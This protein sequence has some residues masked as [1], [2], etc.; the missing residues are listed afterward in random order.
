VLPEVQFLMALDRAGWGWA[1]LKFTSLR[2]PWKDGRG[3]LFRTKSDGAHLDSSKVA[4]CREQGWCAIE[5]EDRMIFAPLVSEESPPIIYHVTPPDN[6]P[7][8]RSRG[9][10]IGRSAGVSTT[11]WPGAGEFIHVA[12]EEEK[13]IDSTGPTGLGIKRPRAEWVLLAIELSGFDGLVYRDPASAWGYMLETD[14]VP[15]QAIS[16]KCRFI[17][18]PCDT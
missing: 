2:L 6:I 13:A 15:P 1:P 9:L 11:N 3:G 7:S 4:W 16:E 17:G 18:S 5:C 8:I 12:F 10:L 14:R